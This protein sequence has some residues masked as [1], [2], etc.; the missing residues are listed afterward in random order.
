MI[1]FFRKIFLISALGFSFNVAAQQVV[2]PVPGTWA[3][4]QTLVIDMPESSNAYYSLSGSDPET[5]GLA[6]DGPVLLE[7]EGDVTVNI[8]IVDKAGNKT[9]KVVSYKVEKVSLPEDEEQRNFI[10]KVTATGA[11]DYSAGD[12]FVIPKSFEYALG[13]SFDSFDAGTSLSMSKEMVISRNM[14]CSVTDGKNAWR[15]IIK[16]H[17][18]MTG[19]YTR[20]DVPFEIKDWETFVFSDKSYIYKIDDQWWGQPKEKVKLDRS[21]NHM[22]SWQS[23]DYSEENIIKFFVVPPKPQLATKVSNEGVVTVSFN[24]A[25]GYK[26]GVIDEKGQVS[27]L[28]ETLTIDTF[29]GDNYSGKITAGLY[30]DSV[31]QGSLS[32]PYDVHKKNPAAPVITP[33]VEGK[34]LR[35]SVKVSIKSPENKVVYAAVTGPVILD[36]NYSVEAQENL[37]DLSNDKFVQMRGKSFTLKPSSEGAAAYKIRAYCVDEVKNISKESVY[38]VIIDQCNYYLDGSITDEEKIAKANGSR[39]YPFVSFRDIVPLINKS[40]FVHVRVSGDV[41][42]PNEKI[43]LS[44]NCQLDGKDSAR[45]IF[46]PKTSFVVRNSSLSLNNILVTLS[47]PQNTLENSLVFQL[48]RSVLYMD[49]AELSFVFGKNGT[50]VNSDNSVVNIQNSGITASAEDYTSIISSVESKLSVKASRITSCAGTAVN[51]SAQGGLFELKDSKCKVVG[52]MGR[53]AELFDTHS[54]IIKNVFDGDLKKGLLSNKAVYM[55]DKNYS[56]EYSS[57]IESGF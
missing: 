31:F 20:K 42:V 48:E 5:S 16:I 23:V 50:V 53:V 37:F 56:V 55:D 43:V 17:P 22:I 30:Y 36:E 15:F 9:S 4:M 18:V 26:F 14:P 35:S 51:F 12:A 33:S 8:V 7:M 34:F 52:S 29:H 28:F 40:R 25:E 10:E 21:K 45:L 27:E 57:N 32:V 3:N 49:K 38:T 54:S 41:Y 47:E 6:Y 1:R 44:S 24:G 11:V 2:N 39:E 13:S 19:V 46:G